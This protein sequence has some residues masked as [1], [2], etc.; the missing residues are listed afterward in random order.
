MEH[1]DNEYV[2]KEDEVTDDK[3]QM[4]IVMVMMVIWMIWTDECHATFV[5]MT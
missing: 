1:S 4:E 3:V 5:I 2:E